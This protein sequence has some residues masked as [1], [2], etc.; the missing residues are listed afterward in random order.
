MDQTSATSTFVMTQC[1]WRT[2]KGV[3]VSDN[4]VNAI[5]IAELI[6]TVMLTMEK[7]EDIPARLKDE[8]VISQGIFNWLENCYIPGRMRWAAKPGPSVHYWLEGIGLAVED[9]PK[10]TTHDRIVQIM[11]VWMN[12]ALT[13]LFTTH[14][15]WRML[16]VTRLGPINFLLSIGQDYR[17]FD[18]MRTHNIDQAGMPDD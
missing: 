4:S 11:D 12:E 15:T 2:I 1:C 16:S 17:I 9:V 6:D 14:M 3:T 13:E 8:S 18:W 5:S 7:A 10:G